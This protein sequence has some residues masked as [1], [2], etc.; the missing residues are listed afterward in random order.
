MQAAG[1]L[2]RL[3]AMLYDTLLLLAILFAATAAALPLNHGE[4]FASDNP[5][6]HAY[7]VFVC[8]GFYGWFWTHGGQT[9]GL[10]AWKLKVLTEDHRPASWRQASIRFIASLVSWSAFGLGFLWILIDKN[11][12]GWHDHLSQTSVFFDP[13][14]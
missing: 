1:F 8:F 14:R 5:Y 10:K 13:N 11:K 9:L 12:R 2:R 4:A 7:L 6:F 3:A